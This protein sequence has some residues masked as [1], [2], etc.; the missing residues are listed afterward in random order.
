MGTHEN[1]NVPPIG[2]A[3]KKGQISTAPEEIFF[4]SPRTQAFLTGSEVIKEAV[5]RS[6]VDF[7]VAYPITPR[8]K[9]LLWSGNFMLMD[10]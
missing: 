6:S 9:R 4:K 5:K 10:M 3:N 7:S 1:P 2:T 8:A